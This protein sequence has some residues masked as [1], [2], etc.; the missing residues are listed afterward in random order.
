M[1]FLLLVYFLLQMKVTF[2]RYS[3]YARFTNE[4][5]HGENSEVLS[6]NFQAFASTC[7]N[8]SLSTCCSAGRLIGSRNGVYL[9]QNTD[10]HCDVNDG[11][12][13]FMKRSSNLSANEFNRSWYHYTR[14][15]GFG[16]LYN[17]HWKGLDLLHELTTSYGMELRIE[18]RNSQISRTISYNYFH[19]GG[20]STDY[21]LTLGSFKGD[22]SLRGFDAHNNSRFSTPDHD[23]NTSHLKCAWFYGGGWW[24]TECFSFFPTGIGIAV[25]G[26]GFSHFDSVEMKIRPLECL[27]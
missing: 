11:W 18:L 27:A 4:D 2:Q 22:E 10:V 26:S 15:E 8:A 6:E 16:D 12:M 24:Y 1:K 20:P 13:T 19:V 14:K 23:H 25:K 9:V 5:C 7:A 21:Q 17:D 3:N